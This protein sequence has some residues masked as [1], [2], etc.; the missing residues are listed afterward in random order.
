MTS[1]KSYKVLLPLGFMF[2]GEAATA[3]AGAVV[4]LDD[5]QAK[6]LVAEGKVELVGDD[7]PEVP[8]VDASPDKAK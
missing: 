1:M 8:P 4:E 5:K 3:W 7:E 6:A 2:N